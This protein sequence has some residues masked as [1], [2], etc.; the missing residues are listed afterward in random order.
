MFM[1]TQFDAIILDDTETSPES[2]AENTDVFFLSEEEQLKLLKA[3]END[4]LS[5]KK[6]VKKKPVYSF[7]KRL[8]DIV[9]SA[10]ALIL[11]SPLFVVVAGKIKRES[12]GPAIFKQLRVGKDGKVFTMYK[13]R[14]MYVDAEERLHAVLELNKGKNSLMFKAED[15]P[16]ITPYGYIIRKRSID[17]LPQLFNILKGE[18]SFVGPRPPLVREVIQYDKEYTIRLAVIGGL[19]CYWQIAGRNDADFGFC[20][21]QDTKYLNE[22]SWWTDIK[23]IF[24][25]IAH[26]FSGKGS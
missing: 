10:L 22:R 26:V 16:R 11:L 4:I 5:M 14:S 23:L 13:F 25:T 17:E 15:D 7:V 19:T 12:E 6:N 18:M 8:F 9:A 3:M 1:E 21:E 2:G 24:M 20:L